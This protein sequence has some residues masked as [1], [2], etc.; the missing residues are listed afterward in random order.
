MNAR[1]REALARGRENARHQ[2]RDRNGNF[3]TIGA[4]RKIRGVSIGIKKF[5]R[6][7]NENP[8]VLEQAL[9]GGLLA[10]LQRAADWERE[11]FQDIRVRRRSI[12]A[13]NDPTGVERIKVHLEVLPIVAEARKGR[14]LAQDLLARSAEIKARLNEGG[15]GYLEDRYGAGARAGP[16]ENQAPPPD[17]DEAEVL[18]EDDAPAEDPPPAE[19]ADPE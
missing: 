1:S 13:D 4:E 14:K 11:A 17:A 19:G 7:L 12:T 10:S 8:D 9:V 18:E 6:A 16:G 15:R 2:P 5:L 3:T